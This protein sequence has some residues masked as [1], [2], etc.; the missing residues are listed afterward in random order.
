MDASGV[1]NIEC[2]AIFA[3]GDR[4]AIVDWDLEFDVGDGGEEP[5]SVEVDDDEAL[6]VVDDIG[7]VVDNREVDW[8]HQRVVEADREGIEAGCF[9]IS[10]VGGLGRSDEEGEG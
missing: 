6:V 8:V 9:R 7:D 10:G 4:W 1:R 2:S 3:Q 5:D